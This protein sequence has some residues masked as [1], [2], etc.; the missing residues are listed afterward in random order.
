MQ[1]QTREKRRSPNEHG[2]N[3]QLES[4]S[5]IHRGQQNVKQRT[6]GFEKEDGKIFGLQKST[7]QKVNP[8]RWLR[9]QSASAVPLD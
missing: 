5:R 4:E 3:A 2:A 7:R 6:G 1:I 8:V 9:L